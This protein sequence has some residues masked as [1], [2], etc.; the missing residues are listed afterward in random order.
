MEKGNTPAPAET[1]A[2]IRNRM[3]LVANRNAEDLENVLYREVPRRK[4]DGSSVLP[5]PRQN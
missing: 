3:E 1:E 2:R 4:R 5:V